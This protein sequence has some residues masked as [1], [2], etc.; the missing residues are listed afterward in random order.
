MGQKRRRGRRK[1]Q[2]LYMMAVAWIALILIASIVIVGVC[3]HNNKEDV[4]QKEAEIQLG[5][6]IDVSTDNSSNENTISSALESELEAEVEGSYKGVDVSRFQGTINWENV[7]SD[8]IDFAMIRV[9]YRDE[10]TGQIVEDSNARY[11]LQ[12]ATKYGIKA[13]AY[14]FSTATTEEEAIEEADFTAD[15]IS[16]YSIT[17]PVAYNCEGFQAAESRMAG[18]SISQ[19]TQ[20]A[21]VFLDRIREQGYTPMFYANR[22]ELQNDA[23]WLTSELENNYKIWIAYYT[24][25][26]ELIKPDYS[27]K[28][29]MWQYTAE[30]SIAGFRHPVDEDIANFSYETVASPKG[31][32]A[33]GTAKADVEALMDFEEVNDRVTAKDVVNLRELPANN[34]TS[35][36]LD[37][38]SNGQIAT[39]TGI[40]DSGWSRLEINGNIYY[41]VSSYLTTDLSTKVTASQ[42]ETGNDTIAEDI[43]SEDQ[44]YQIK[45]QFTDCD[46]YLTAKSMTN[47]RTLP[48][49]TNADSSVV[50]TLYNGEVVH[51]TGYNTE[52]G[53]SRV[54][55]DGQVLYCVTS[56]MTQ[57]Q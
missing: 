29:A 34:D 45:T 17:Y 38:L 4:A 53:W 14:F 49:V 51:R 6:D 28:Y 13:G 5:T 31:I 2:R 15:L 33:D 52:Y 56:Y 27:G 21:K 41:A 7:A 43:P 55:Y 47:L 20:M 25:E 50:K 57:A 22:N 23:A 39:R 18:M 30:G 11:N 40:S 24:N 32:P 54:E 42:T 16:G 10:E 1:Q 26:E 8:G 3:K 46:D 44:G 35:A 36:I 48:S 9:G 37:T 12:E 19:R